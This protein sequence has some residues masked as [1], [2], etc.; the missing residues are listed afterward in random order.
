[1]CRLNP[2]NFGHVACFALSCGRVWVIDVGIN[3]HHDIKKNNKKAAAE[4]DTQGP[5][6]T[7]S[8]SPRSGRPPR[9]SS[10]FCFPLTR[11]HCALVLL[12]VLPASWAKLFSPP[13]A[14]TNPYR[15]HQRCKP[16]PA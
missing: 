6:P 4:S 7:G 9:W 15:K 3:V 8:T 14:P 13:I 10:A 2:A 16:W 11:I 5:Q 12:M 1:M